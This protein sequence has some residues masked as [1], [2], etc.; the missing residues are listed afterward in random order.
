[1][2]LIIDITEEDR[3]DI[4]NIHFVREDLKFKIGKAI[5]NGTPLDGNSDRAEAQAYFLGQSYGWEQGRKAMID[6]VMSVFDDF[7]CGEVDEDGAD[8]FR[9]MLKDKLE[10]EE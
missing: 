3:K 5:M 8:I 4:G 10:S 2:K 6:D 1:M 9:E 7:M